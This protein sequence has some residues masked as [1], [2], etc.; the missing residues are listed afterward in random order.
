MKKLVGDARLRKSETTNVDSNLTEYPRVEN[1]NPWKSKHSQPAAQ[2]AP[3]QDYMQTEHPL[4][5]YPGRQSLTAYQGHSHPV[6]KPKA[7]FNPPQ[8][9]YKQ[10][11]PQPSNFEKKEEPPADGGHIHPYGNN[12]NC[13][14]CNK[15]S[16]PAIDVEA[17]LNED[18]GISV[19]FTELM[20]EITKYEKNEPGN[21]TNKNSGQ[22]KN[23]AGQ[24]KRHEI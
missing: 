23:E 5:N 20:E 11:N 24:E 3:I 18:D 4:A 21:P 10:S 17:F 7:P 14:V 6:Q 8:A 9:I 1:S 13:P 19:G 15:A 22:Q 2:Q 16:K 12:A